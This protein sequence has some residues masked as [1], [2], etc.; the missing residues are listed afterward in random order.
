M[1]QPFD[2]RFTQQ[3]KTLIAEDLTRLH[4][5]LGNGSQIVPDAATTGMKCTG[6]MGEIKAMKRALDLIDHVND[7]LTGKVKD[8]KKDGQDRD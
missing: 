4:T 5:E 2:V 1:T 6:Y 7:K 3:L 8:T